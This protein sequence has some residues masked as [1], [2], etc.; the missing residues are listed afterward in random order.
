MVNC[1]KFFFIDSDL[2]TYDQSDSL[3]QNDSSPLVTTRSTCKNLKQLC[4]ICNEL[5]EC[6]SNSYSSGKM[7]KRRFKSKTSRKND[8]ISRQEKQGTQIL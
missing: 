7:R 1:R 4:F 2:Q 5:Q 6:D 8:T 3:V